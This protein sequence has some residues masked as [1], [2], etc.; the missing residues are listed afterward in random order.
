MTLGKRW[1]IRDR[2]GHEIYLTDERW[3]HILEFHDEMAYF[4]NE[5]V[6]TLK[7]GRRRQDALNTSIYT[8]FYPF[9]HL[10]YRHTHI[11]AIVKSKPYSTDHFVL[12]AYQKTIYSQR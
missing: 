6:V 2:Y 9:N 7:R 8:Y 11:I 10:L 4:E 1:I 3:D 5:L 12:T